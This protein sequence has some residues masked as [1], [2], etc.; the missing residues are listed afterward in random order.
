M[1][2]DG[3]LEVSGMLQVVLN[4]KLHS[5][6]SNLV[7]DVGKEWV[8]GMMNGVG[9][10]IAFMAVGTNPTVAAAGQTTLSAEIDRNALTGGAGVVTANTIQYSCTWGDGAGE[11]ALREAGLF[12]NASGG[13]MLARTVF[14]EINKGTGDVMTIIW[15]ITVA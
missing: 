14:D 9:T 10:A 6:F 13:A 15:T 4:G 8:A 5:E 7:V 11:G 1:D 2:F 3:K 12:D